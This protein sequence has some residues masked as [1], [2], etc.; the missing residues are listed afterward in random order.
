[1]AV[2]DIDIVGTCNLSCPSCPTGNFTIGDFAAARKRPSGMM[3]LD[4]FRAI[5]EKIAREL[6]GNHSITLFNWGEPLLHPQVDEF[7]AAIKAYP[8][9]TSLVST[10]LNIKSDLAPLVRS[11]PHWLRVSLSG[12]TQD[13]YARTHRDGNVLLVKSNLYRL[14]Y[15]M[16]L[17]KVNFHVEMHYHLYKS[18]I[19]D[20]IPAGLA[21]REL[22]FAFRPIEAGLMP[23]EK[24]LK[25]AEGHLLSV[26]D[27][28]VADN[29]LVS[30]RERAALRATSEI[31][32]CVLRAEQFAINFDGSVP[33][34]CSTF[35]YANNVADDILDV[36]FAELQRKRYSHPT[37]ARCF[38]AKL[39][40]DR[41]DGQADVRV[42]ELANRRVKELGGRFSY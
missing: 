42:R 9:F 25:V 17:L 41:N 3:K 1:M 31:R 33:L 13:V 16:D 22:N 15:L 38:K 5:L 32:D 10:N 26:E 37:C 19:A 21:A 34:C 2:F 28:A 27:Q 8:E 39:A 12:W 23:L 40:F 20:V 6:P 29:L 7:I 11:Q 36:S 14:R 4:L 35:D 30:L 24:A 18:N